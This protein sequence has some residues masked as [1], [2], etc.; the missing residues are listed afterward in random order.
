MCVSAT[1]AHVTHLRTDTLSP[2][3]RQQVAR[4]SHQVKRIPSDRSEAQEAEKVK[5][6]K[7]DVRVG[8]Q[9]ETAASAARPVVDLC[10]RRARIRK[11]QRPGLDRIVERFTFMSVIG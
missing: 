5:S 3:K 2:M 8:V 1:N 10:E 6:W 9:M 11:Q 7:R 4:L